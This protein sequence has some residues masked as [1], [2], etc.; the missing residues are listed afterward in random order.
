MH[1]ATR[2]TSG[3]EAQLET[4]T[5]ELPGRQPPSA[6]LGSAV[7]TAG[8]QQTPVRAAEAGEKCLPQQSPGS[9]GDPQVWVRV[10]ALTLE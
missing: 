5:Q 8:I 1:P 4:M 9:F 6:G 7:Y 2:M 3:S 10:P